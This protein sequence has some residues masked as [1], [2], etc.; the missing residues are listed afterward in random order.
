MFLPKVPTFDDRLYNNLEK[1]KEKRELGNVIEHACA[2]PIL[3]DSPNTYRIH[4]KLYV[5]LHDNCSFRGR[6]VRVMHKTPRPPTRV[7][8][9]RNSDDKSNDDDDNEDVQDARGEECR[10]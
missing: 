8:R 5:C 2:S 7:S 4:I 10:R 1:K 3:Q 9:L 6:R